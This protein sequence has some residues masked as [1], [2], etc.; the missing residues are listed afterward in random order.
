[1]LISLKILFIV[2]IQMMKLLDVE[3]Q[4]HCYQKIKVK[5]TC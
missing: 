1:M 4:S 3:A 2:L 5:L